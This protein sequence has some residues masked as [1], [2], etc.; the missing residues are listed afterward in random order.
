MGLNIPR[1]ELERVDPDERV[2]P[3]QHK[4]VAP[5]EP[6]LNAAMFL[7][8]YK[9]AAD[10]RSPSPPEPAFTDWKKQYRRENKRSLG[11]DNAIDYHAT[12]FERPSSFPLADHPS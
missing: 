11:A 10:R 2:G 1:S 8:R 12:R 4:G 6:A 5:L 9:T 3:D 7:P